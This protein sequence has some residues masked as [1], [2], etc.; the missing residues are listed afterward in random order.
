MKLTTKVKQT[1]R[2][3]LKSSIWL[4]L[5]LFIVVVIVVYLVFDLGADRKE[6]FISTD[7][8]FV[9]KKGDDIYDSFYADIYDFLVY[10]QVKNDYEFSE[11]KD[12]TKPTTKSVILDIGSGTG[13]HVN[14]MKKRGLNV[15]GVDKS[16]AMVRVARKKYPNCKFLV[17]DVM[18][19]LFYSP[20]TF[21]HIT[22]FYFTI[23]YIKD[24]YTF[25]QNCYSWLMAGGYLVIHLVNRSK[26]NPILD[27]GDPLTLISPQKY[28]PK[29]ITSTYVT[30]KDYDYKSNFRLDE[31]QD[32]AYMEEFFMDKTKEKAMKNEHEFFMPTQKAI[33]HQAKRA[34][35]ILNAKMNLVEVEYEYQYLYVLQKPG[36]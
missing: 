34:G 8:K 19:S 32:K 29:R 28:A 4:K 22:C 27:V 21:T 11:F 26:F 18:D 20:S 10:N 14:T 2:W 25:F 36:Y 17:G 3:F 24:K 9:Y 13:H 15:Q 23:Y 16:T 30:F 7:K 35:F 12:K 1:Y 5:L 33:L 6:S 31:S